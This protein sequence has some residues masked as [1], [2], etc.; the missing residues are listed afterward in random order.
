MKKACSNLTTVLIGCLFSLVTFAQNNVTITGNVRGSVNNESVSAVSVIIKGTEEGTYT[1]ERGNFRLTTSHRFPLTLVFTS[2]GYASQDVVVRN[3]SQPV[4]VIF[5]PGTAFAQEVTVSASRLQERVLESPVTVERISSANIRNAPAVSYYDMVGTLRGVDVTTSSLTFKTPST[6]GFNTSGNLRL[7]QQ[8]D[9]MDNQ[10]PGLNFPVGGMIGPTDLDV[11]SV[12]LLAGASSALYGPGGMNGTLLIN[13]KNPFKYQGLSVQ[14]KQGVMHVDERQR[15]MSPYYDYSLRF[16]KALSDKFA[17]K[18]GGQF[19]QAKDWVATDTSNYTVTGT[20][21]GSKL[22]GS[23][24]ND[25]NY[26]GVNVYGDETTLDVRA[27]SSPFLQG[28]IQGSPNPAVY[29]AI[30]A[31]YLTSPINVS[32]TG[33]KESD[34][35]D[36]TTKNIRLNGSLNYKIT[37]NTEASFLAN[38]GTGTT[39]YTGSDRYSLKDFIMAQYKLEV[40]NKNWFLRAYTTQEDAGESFNATVTTRIFNEGWKPSYNPANAAGSW[41]PQ[42]ATVFATAALTA[43]QTAKAQGASDAAAQAAM[44]A[45]TPAYHAAARAFA[46]Q[47]RPAPGS[48]QFNSIFNSVRSIPISK[49]GGLFIDKSS[50]Y[51][52]EGQY[53]FSDKVKFAEVLVGASFKRYVLNSEGTLFADTTGRIGINEAGAYALIS[54]RLFKDVLKLT[55]SGRYD[56]NQNFQGHFTPRISAVVS[57]AKNHNIRLSYQTAYRF[58]STQN[59]WINLAVGGGVRLIGGLP[60]LR[61]F[62]HFNTNPVYTQAS[63]MQFAASGNPALLVKQEF[64]DYKPES[65]KSYEVGYKGLITDK[66]LFDAYYYYTEY[67]D[68]LGR[69]VVFQSSNGNPNPNIYSVATNSTSKVNTHG[70]GASL[71]YQLPNNFSVNAN[72]FSDEITNVPANFVAQYNAPKYRSN[73]GL[74]NSGF[75]YEKRVGFT[76][77]YRYQGSVYYQGDFTTG[78]IPSYNTVD[79]QIN[80]KFPKLKSMI[81]VGGT[82]IFNHYYKTA[83]GNPEIGGLYYASIAY[84]VF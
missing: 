62:Y 65:V 39:V 81:K 53:N 8:V 52:T 29:G 13:S 28:V 35:I 12:E 22:P 47:G 4:N 23:R 32:R 10:A 57:V 27:S 15:S 44:L 68:F 2:I 7:T 72:L 71:E 79:A 5:Q 59:Q 24:T 70:W 76:V 34:I 25:P 66:L 48:D 31:P 21:T 50:L 54:K 49:G 20:G 55:A 67:K 46:D 61:D 82:N 63:F 30:L 38:W 78:D 9:G 6:R 45:N 58:P 33:Y 75:L 40:K 1:D 17:F 3:A 18:I 69:I 56:K 74:S 73:I 26:N 77:Q 19:I 11:E 64:G 80:Y 14:V 43:Y 51:M 42:Y 60:A 36:P 83:Y 16:A 41:Y 84:N 37:P